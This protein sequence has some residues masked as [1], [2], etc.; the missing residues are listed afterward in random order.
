MA[1]ISNKTIYPQDE[2]VT[3]EDYLIGT[4]AN[5]FN[6]T[7]TY[8]VQSFFNLFNLAFK[9]SDGSE[10]SIDYSTK[11]YFFTEDNETD[12]IQVTR[13]YFNNRNL[14][15]QNITALFGLLAE[16]GDFVLRLTNSTDPN[17][18][19]FITCSDLVFDTVSFSFDSSIYAGLFNGILQND[20]AYAISFEIAASSSTEQ[21]N[22]HKPKYIIVNG[23]ISELIVA[24]T[25]N[26]S[27]PFII[28]DD[29][30]PL[31]V[32]F[33]LVTVPTPKLTT[34]KYVI[35]NYG[36]GTYGQG[37]N[38]T[39]TAEDVELMFSSAPSTNDIINDP[40]TDIVIIPD[41]GM[42]TISQFI[43]QSSP[44]YVIQDQ[45]DGLT[46]FQTGTDPNV[47]AYLFLGDGGTYGFGQ[48]QTTDADFQL[49]T[50]N[51]GNPITNTSQLINDGEDGDNPFVT[52]EDINTS[53][54]T[55]A[56]LVGGVVPSY[57][58]PSYVD[59]VLEFANLA[60]FPVTGETGKIYIA[61]D[62]NKQ[63]RWSGSAYIQ[64]TNGLIAST[65]D[66]PEGSNLYFTV[67][68]VLAT[69]LTGVS[70][71]TGTPIVSTDS[72]LIAFGK[73]Q[74][75]ITDVIASVALKQ[76]LLVSG[77]NIKTVNGNT[78]LGSGNLQLPRSGFI[79][80]GFATTNVLANTGWYVP[81][82]ESSNIF[83]NV[84]VVDSTYTN[85]NR[86]VSDARTAG[87]ILP[88]DCRIKSIV[89][90]SG[91]IG[92]P[93][94]LNIHSWTPMSSVATNNHT[95]GSK[96]ISATTGGDNFIFSGSEI[97]TTTILTKNSRISCFLFN[98]NVATGA[99]RFN[100]FL[101]EI[102]EVI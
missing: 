53:I 50:D 68:R 60:A 95:V 11:G 26:G 20:K 81:T 98:N 2:N 4:N 58:L 87:A 46:V 35:N 61:D 41:L 5:N 73:L 31:I 1:K 56:D 19:I 70:F 54:S 76:N 7:Q 9:Y 34:Y 32:I 21:D 14:L 74:K 92:T 22:K 43:N 94:T 16:Q 86:L 62:T 24:N 72:V 77:T 97:D 39:L 47:I 30:I 52:Q 69:L 78:L 66:V 49:I 51:A 57:Q 63:Y 90:S 80:L 15:G 65:T 55:K 6:R 91:S 10:P 82:R 27:L 84:M 42:L 25:I 48:L 75:Q 96:V 36:K 33:R 59:D 67:A 89:W 102:E 18:V 17:N 12:P 38:I 83:Q 45:G 64:I 101:I 13:F 28:N 93:L 40:S 79:N 99:L 23:D 3:M 88:F 29:E 44:S 85:A 100:L 71:V 8:S 37:G